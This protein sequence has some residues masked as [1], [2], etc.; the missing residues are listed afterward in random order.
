MYDMLRPCD[1]LGYTRIIQAGKILRIDFI[2]DFIPGIY[3]PIYNMH[4]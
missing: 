4:L 2:T 1:E 3:L